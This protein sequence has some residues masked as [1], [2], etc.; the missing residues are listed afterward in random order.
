[1]TKSYQKYRSRI[2]FISSCV[3]MVWLCLSIRLIKI[4]A[5]DSNHYRQIGFKQSQKQEPLNAVRGNI[6]DRNEVQLTK[7][8][9]H[10]SIGAHPQ[11]IENKNKLASDLSKIT[12]RDIDYYLNRLNYSVL[13]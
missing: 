7:N 9:I 13:Y 1:M 11:K 3:V 4:M 2:I 10:Y 5:F 8:I 12:G 6:F